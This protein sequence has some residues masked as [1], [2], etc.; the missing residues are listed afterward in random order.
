M[1]K[2]TE[3]RDLS[4]SL[5]VLVIAGWFILALYLIAFIVG[6]VIGAM[7]ALV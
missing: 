6:F 7:E 2:R 3:F 5:K 1:N 4:T